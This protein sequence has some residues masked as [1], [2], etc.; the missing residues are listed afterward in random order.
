MAADL[1]T[2]RLYYPEYET[3]S[4]EELSA[5]LGVAEEEGIS[6]ESYGA[7]LDVPG[8]RPPADPRPPEAIEA[9]EQAA[10][11]EIQALLTERDARPTPAFSPDPDDPAAATRTARTE[12]ALQ[13]MDA[14]AG[15]ALQAARSR[16]PSAGPT[17]G[18]TAAG[19]GVGRALAGVGA[20][21]LKAGESAAGRP[22]GSPPSPAGELA[23][24]MER[25][26]AKLPYEPGVAGM[27]EGL[28]QFMA[29]FGA[30]AK[31]AG[32]VVKG[33]PIIQTALASG[34]TG[35]TAF[36]GQQAR[37]SDLVQQHPRL[38]NPVTE[39]LQ[40]DP[41]DGFAEGRLKNA[42]EFAGL[43]VA[44][45][46]PFIVAMRGIRGNA[47][48]AK[49]DG[50]IEMAEAL[51]K[52][53]PRKP[54]GSHTGPLIV[55]GK[56]K[57]AMVKAVSKGFGAIEGSLAK[58]DRL[59]R[60]VMSRVEE[61]GEG[62]G[63]RVAFRLNEFEL[64]QNLLMGKHFRQVEPFL[65]SYR[66]MSKADRKLFDRHA[67]NSEM[68]EAY[69]VL[70]RNQRKIPGIKSEFDQLRQGLE[71]MHK[72]GVDSGLDIPYRQH[73]LRRNV[74]DY[75]GLLDHLRA[76]S[77]LQRKIKES[78]AAKGS[79]EEREVIREWLESQFKGDGRPGF[80]QNR[81]IDKLDDDMLKFYGGFEDTM[82]NYVRNLTYRV[83]KN[84]FVGASPQKA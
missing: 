67:L 2:F 78:G 4:D 84:R 35:A 54:T 40:S 23:D 34:A 81:V 11:D 1:Q 37:L 50:N 26:L 18:E 74:R 56:V 64:E 3:L 69:A 57:D 8:T 41:D 27:T 58:G 60:P 12:Q 39:F 48:R 16:P 5:R 70:A 43:D 10:L 32:A 55:E 65:L 15:M 80:V 21:A 25:N 44:I 75:K 30:L 46:A 24:T 77:P 51:E 14:Q 47:A 79:F 29:P 9:E 45:A 6:I 28:V 38:K 42:L 13:P 22:P 82:Q 71:D 7:L 31:G 53:K 76:N 63:K 72:L 36:S 73:Y 49:P 17:M 20:L 59:W 19:K 83:A 61:I 66:K 52:V 33:R 68:P 62:A